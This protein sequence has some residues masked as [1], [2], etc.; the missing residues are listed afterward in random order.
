MSVCAQTFVCDPTLVY[1]YDY[2]FEFNSFFKR[3]TVL[4][5]LKTQNKHKDYIHEC[6]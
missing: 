4:C 6:L 2:A 1:N 3:E 5:H